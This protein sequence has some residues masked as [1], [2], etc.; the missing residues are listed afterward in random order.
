M[1]QGI[2]TIVREE[3]DRFHLALLALAFVPLAIGAAAIASERFCRYSTAGSYR[4][5]NYQK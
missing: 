4:C 2:D 5:S 1:N 3:Q